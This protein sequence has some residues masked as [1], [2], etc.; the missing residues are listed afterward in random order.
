MLFKILKLLF[1][2]NHI[3]VS[4]PPKCKSNKPEIFVIT[5]NETLNV[6]CDVEAAPDDVIFRWSLETSHGSVILQ[7]WNSSN[8]YF[9]SPLAEYGPGT[10]SC[11]GRNSVDVQEV[12]CQFKLVI[13]SK[14]YFLYMYLD[15][16]IVDV[17]EIFRMHLYH[18]QLGKSGYFFAKYFVNLQC[19]LQIEKLCTVTPGE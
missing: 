5:E 18:R 17:P 9:Y 10:L 7:K 6:T 14:E 13:A 3:F 16:Y 15:F 11:W 4:V 12:P 1:K 19:Y 2:K 8:V